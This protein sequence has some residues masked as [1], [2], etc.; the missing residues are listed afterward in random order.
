[1][2]DLECDP[3]TRIVNWVRVTF[4]EL[5][6][7]WR[8]AQLWKRRAQETSARDRAGLRTTWLRCTAAGTGPGG[9]L[10]RAGETTTEDAAHDVAIRKT[11]A[12]RRLIRPTLAR[13]SETNLRA[14][15]LELL[16]QPVDHRRQ[17]LE[18]LGD[19]A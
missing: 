16:V 11:A 7:P 3:L 10:A 15:L 9:V 5:V 18:P 13:E 6:S 19:H 17:L 14:L 4:I 8:A 2:L 1:M 12:G